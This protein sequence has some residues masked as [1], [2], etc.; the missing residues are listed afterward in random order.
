M[1]KRLEH[2]AKAKQMTLDEIAAFI[3]GARAAGAKGTEFPGARVTWGGKLMSLDVVVDDVEG[4]L[5]PSSDITDSIPGT[6][7][8][9]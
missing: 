5:D 6:S 9:E 3:A 8:S 7:S 2:K 4:T 1:T